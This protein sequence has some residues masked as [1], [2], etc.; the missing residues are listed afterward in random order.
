[1]I[2]MANVF[3]YFVGGRVVEWKTFYPSTLDF[4]SKINKFVFVAKK[5]QGCKDERVEVLQTLA[6]RSLKPDPKRGHP[7]RMH[8]SWS[9][10]TYGLGGTCAFVLDP[11]SLEVTLH[12]VG[13]CGWVARLVCRAFSDASCHVTEA[14][15]DS[16]ERLALVCNVSTWRQPRNLCNFAACAG[17]LEVLQ[18][19]RLN[20]CRWDAETCSLAAESGHLEVLQW[21]RLSGCPWDEW[22]CI[23]AALNGHL[24][25]LQWARLQGCPWNEMTCCYAAQQGHLEVL[26]WARLNGCPWDD[27]TCTLAANK[28]HLE[29]LQWA[30][31]NGCPG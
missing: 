10:V 1:M 8:Y 26:Q 20:G 30:R 21:A 2:A 11:R 12:L 7:T 6:V 22:T 29:I 17:H 28:G 4:F 3:I 5:N 15:I 24:E 19:A 9:G 13:D 14:S 18:W 16:V 25:V 31:L 23:Y 27:L